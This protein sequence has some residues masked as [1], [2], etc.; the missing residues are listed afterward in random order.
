M[1]EGIFTSKMFCIVMVVVLLPVSSQ[2]FAQEQET[3]RIA[4]ADFEISG[5]KFDIPDIEKVVTEWLTTFLVQTGAFEVVERQRLQQVLEEQKLGQTGILDETSAAQVGEILGVNVL[6]TG[7]LIGFE[8][9]LEVTARMIDSTNA[10]LVGV[11]SVIVE[12][13]DKLRSQ[14]KELAEIIRRKLTKRQ[15]E[16]EAKVF[17]TFD[18]NELN[19]NRWIFECEEGIKKADEENTKLVQEQGVLRVTGKYGEKNDELRL[20]WLAP[21]SDTR[22]HSL[23]AKVQVRDVDGGAAICLGTGW[24]EKN[25]TGIC[26]YFEKEGGIVSVG[27]EDP[28]WVDSPFEFD[29]QLNQWYVMRFEYKEE[30]F[31]YYWNNQLIKTITPD[32]PVGSSLDLL[33]VGFVFEETRAVTIE[34]DELILR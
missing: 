34:L 24:A 28:E 18:E 5:Q 21:N 19:T 22:Y 26:P 17:E 25:W 23:E 2:V 9:T 30:Q 4:V 6:V 14:V 27:I 12:D 8:D 1:K 13:M 29:I 3:I 7:T 32:T 33:I 16:E 20:C 31:F 15:I 11:E 10:V